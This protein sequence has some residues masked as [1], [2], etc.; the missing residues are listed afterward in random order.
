[1]RVGTARAPKSLIWWRYSLEGGF[2][3]GSTVQDATA[4]G[5]YWAPLLSET[6]NFPCL[7]NPR[8]KSTDKQHVR[9]SHRN[10]AQPYSQ[11]EQHEHNPADKSG[12]SNGLGTRPYPRHD[13]RNILEGGTEQRRKVHSGCPSDAQHEATRHQLNPEP[14]TPKKGIGDTAET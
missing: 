1:M 2:L 10:L 12:K 13:P 11:E 6:P 8:C 7:P 4:L 3:L 9:P 14:Q 5:L